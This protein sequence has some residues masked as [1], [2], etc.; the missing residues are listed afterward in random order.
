MTGNKDETPMNC[1]QFPGPQDVGVD[2]WM[3]VLMSPS[4]TLEDRLNKMR[5]KASVAPATVT[6]ISKGEVR[7]TRKKAG[8]PQNVASPVHIVKP[9]IRVW[10]MALRLAKGNRKRLEVVEPTTVIVHNHTNWKARA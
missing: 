7:R 10:K 2:G 5:D 1:G 4:V 8:K 3:A 9:D 6:A